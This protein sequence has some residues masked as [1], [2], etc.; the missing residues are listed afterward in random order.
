LDYLS[1]VVAS[2]K[3]VFFLYQPL[4]FVQQPLRRTLQQYSYFQ[5]HA[6]F[7]FWKQFIANLYLQPVWGISSVG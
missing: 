7:I 4:H 6:S 1:H 2:K 5:P 3:Q